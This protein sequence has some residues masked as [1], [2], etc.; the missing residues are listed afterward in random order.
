MVS[1]YCWWGECIG[2]LI[3]DRGGHLSHLA[4]R[5][6]QEMADRHR[7]TIWTI[8]H[9]G[10]LSGAHIPCA[11]HRRGDDQRAVAI[12]DIIR[13]CSVLEN[14]VGTIEVLLS[15]NCWSVSPYSSS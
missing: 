10:V 6:I 14:K 1:G 7:D 9:P 12:H 3:L 11:S 5:D 4:F 13:S 8:S 15:S 2:A